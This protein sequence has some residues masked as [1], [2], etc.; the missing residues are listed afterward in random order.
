MPGARRGI[1]A[2]AASAPRALSFDQRLAAGLFALLALLPLLS[3]AT[4]SSYWLLVGE[5]AVIFAIAA[6]SLELLIGAGAMATRYR[7]R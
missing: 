6:L 1:P 5:R 7:L 2:A 4:A 3:H